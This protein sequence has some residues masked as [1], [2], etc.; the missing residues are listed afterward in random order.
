MRTVWGM[1]DGWAVFME[2]SPALRHGEPHHRVVLGC[3]GCSQSQ[4][5]A[6]EWPFQAAKHHSSET[7]GAVASSTCLQVCAACGKQT[8]LEMC[9]KGALPT[10]ITL[11]HTLCA[12][13]GTC[14]SAVQPGTASKP[15]GSLGKEWE[16]A[17]V[18]PES[19]KECEVCGWLDLE[20]HTQDLEMLPASVSEPGVS[21]LVPWDNYLQVPRAGWMGLLCRGALW[22]PVGALLCELFPCICF[23]CTSPMFYCSGSIVKVL[24]TEGM[25]EPSLM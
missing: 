17:A 5:G 10:G 4:A 25:S 8:A 21:A 3:M 2:L 23:L 15:T 13:E 18:S 20:T 16:L 14:I 24:N 19:R 9:C 6:V 7:V 22:M 11:L 12:C 1:S